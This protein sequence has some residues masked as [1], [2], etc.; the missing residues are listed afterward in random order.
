MIPIELDEEHF[1]SLQEAMPD[2][3]FKQ[4]TI[5]PPEGLKDKISDIPVVVSKGEDG[6][7]IHTFWKPEA[8]ETI[9]LEHGG[10]IE[11]ALWTSTMPPVSGDIWGGHGQPEE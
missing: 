6:L 1:R 10:V 5:G 2:R 7:R 4:V 9:V 8:D 11:F 3:E